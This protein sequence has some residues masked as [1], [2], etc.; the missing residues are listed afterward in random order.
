MR[1]TAVCIVNNEKTR[2]KLQY[3][4]TKFK[5]LV[6]L[7]VDTYRGEYFGCFMSIIAYKRGTQCVEYFS[8]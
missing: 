1:T 8:H 5:L 2:K 7:H 3:H 4:V 6:E